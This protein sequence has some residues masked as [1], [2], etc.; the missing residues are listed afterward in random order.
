MHHLL[1][2]HTELPESLELGG[3]GSLELED[4]EDGDATGPASQALSL[5]LALPR[6]LPYPGLSW[7]SVHVPLLG[8]YEWLPTPSVSRHVHISAHVHAHAHACSMCM[9]MR[10]QLVPSVSRRYH[11]CTRACGVCAYAHT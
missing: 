1:Q 2:E 10:R 9:C 11:L 6:A 8:E 4:D 5:K 7:R 3:V